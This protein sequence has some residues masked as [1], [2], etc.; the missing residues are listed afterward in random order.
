MELRKAKNRKGVIKLKL[1]S[2]LETKYEDID[3]R[4]GVSFRLVNGLASDC[5]CGVYIEDEGVITIP[6]GYFTIDEV[7]DVVSV[8]GNVIK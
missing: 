8:E 6:G 7:Y 1:R 4:I 2:V 3:R 5:Y